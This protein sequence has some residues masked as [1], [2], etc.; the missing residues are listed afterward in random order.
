MPVFATM[1]AAGV[2]MA[3]VKPEKGFHVV[4]KDI[5]EPASPAGDGQRQAALIESSVTVP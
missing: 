4:D 1:E 5:D 3:I 2:L